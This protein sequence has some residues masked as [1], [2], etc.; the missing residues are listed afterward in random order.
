MGVLTIVFDKNACPGALRNATV[1]G[2]AVGSVA[3]R[4]HGRRR[5]R[6]EMRQ[7]MATAWTQYN[8][9][10]KSTHERGPHAS[11]TSNFDGVRLTPTETNAL[12][13]TIVAYAL[14]RYATVSRLPTT[15]EGVETPPSRS[16]APNRDWIQE[17]R[18]TV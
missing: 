15:R 13:D 4:I 14:L 10:G 5:I 1:M 17:P 7:P 9:D 2:G 18:C 11:K 16:T 3:I 12:D 6:R 8:D